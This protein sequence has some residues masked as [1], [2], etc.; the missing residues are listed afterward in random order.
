[1]RLLV[2]VVAF[3]LL[4]VLLSALPAAA[5]MRAPYARDGSFS[6]HV[7][8]A[9]PDA[10]LMRE[11]F[12]ARLP[13]FT[14]GGFDHDMDARIEVEYDIDNTSTQTLRLP[15]R[16]LAVGADDAIVRVNGA[17][18]AVTRV[19]DVD[20]RR[21]ARL[22]I[23]RH[24]CAWQA[25]DIEGMFF[26]GCSGDE[27]VDAVEADRRYEDKRAYAEERFDS[28]AFDVELVPGANTVRVEYRQH[29]RFR[30]GPHGYFT[31]IGV[32]GAQYGFEYLLY[33]AESWRR[34]D[35][36]TF[37][38]HVDVPHVRQRGLFSDTHLVP[39]L[40]TNLPLEIRRQPHPGTTATARLRDFFSADV[41]AVVV[42]V[43]R[44]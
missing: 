3:A 11:R 10:L 15:V 4:S 30:E 29:L 31:G 27:A 26:R 20:E 9:H 16:F 28:L 43:P 32:R 36:F 21:A 12:V 17:P 34:H 24:R 2:V 33:P 44:D 8:G 39:S 38:V 13:S 37:D 7:R 41:L 22:R 40:R 1:M 14:T 35:D 5:N 42:E 18:V 25:H 19:A 6:E 23:A